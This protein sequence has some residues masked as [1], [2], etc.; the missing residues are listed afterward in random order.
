MIEALRQ[1][2][3]VKKYK[4][5]KVNKAIVQYHC[6]RLHFQ[7]L[8]LPINKI[9]AQQKDSIEMYL[10]GYIIK[11]GEIQKNPVE[12]VPTKSTTGADIFCT[13]FNRL[14]FYKLPKGM[15]LVEST[16]P[17]NIKD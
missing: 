12:L 7:K 6:V 15:K 9:F 2:D 8:I 3:I 10:S 13:Y 14:H 17:V 16:D 11:K 4:H 5:P 1:K